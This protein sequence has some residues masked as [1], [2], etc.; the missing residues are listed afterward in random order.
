MIARK[1]A[2]EKK[3]AVEAAA[4]LL[5]ACQASLLGGSRPRAGGAASI[6]QDNESCRALPSPCP[7]THRARANPHTAMIMLRRQA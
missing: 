3:N 1:A 7:H 4:A 2:G 6:S 5:V